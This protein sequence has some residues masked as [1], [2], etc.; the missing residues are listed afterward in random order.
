MSI[1]QMDL[2]DTYRGEYRDEETAGEKYG[3]QAEVLVQNIKNRGAK[4]SL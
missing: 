4:V 1:F 3:A 2:P